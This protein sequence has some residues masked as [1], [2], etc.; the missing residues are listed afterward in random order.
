MLKK[1]TV[2]LA[3]EHPYEHIAFNVLLLVLGLLIFAYLYFV[4]ASIL[5]VVARREAL[6]QS[7]RIESSIGGLEQRYFS[8][9]QELTPDE[10][11]RLGLVPLTQPSYVDRP[12]NVGQANVTENAI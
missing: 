10:G 1:K 4:A 12:G 3:V 6:A 11:S 2:V 9:S 8:L 5:N 7:D